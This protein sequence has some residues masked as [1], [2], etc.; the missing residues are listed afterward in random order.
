MISLQDTSV[1]VPTTLL[2]ICTYVQYRGSMVFLG[3]LCN[4]VLRGTALGTDLK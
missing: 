2:S 1:L 3:I 4:A